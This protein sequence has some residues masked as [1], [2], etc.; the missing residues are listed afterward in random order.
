MTAKPETAAEVLAEMRQQTRDGW[1]SDGRLCQF[2]DR[3]ERALSAQSQSYDALL[4]IA[5]STVGALERAGVTDC[6][7]PGEAID[8]LRE[9]WERKLSAQG[10]AARHLVDSPEDRFEQFVQAEI[11]RSPEPLRELGEYLADALDEDKFPRANAL[12]LQ[13]ATSYTHPAPAAKPI[14][15]KNEASLMLAIAE[16]IAASATPE[17][18]RLAVADAISRHLGL[19]WPSASHPAPVRV[20]EEMVERARKAT[21]CNGES[22]EWEIALA[23]KRLIPEA[24]NSMVRE[25]LRTALTAALEDGRHG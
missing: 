6:D 3:L 9:R 23:Y 22:V 10:E 21:V 12:L 16:F 2:A 5:Q 14:T 8:V 7:D 24:R 20:T 19:G 13:L 11:A 15:R 18:P 25:V 17:D 1:T 4:L